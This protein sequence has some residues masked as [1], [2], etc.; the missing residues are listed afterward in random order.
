MKWFFVLACGLGL[1]S[2]S[3]RAA[4]PIA[5]RANTAGDLAAMCAAVPNSPAADAKINYCLGF[6]QGAVDVELHYAE[7]KK[8]FCIP[9][10]TKRSDT[11]RE[12]AAWARVLP[13][14]RDLPAAHGLIKFLGERF[15]CKS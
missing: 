14:N 7:E 3:V 15:P 11:M 13:A 10:G 9:D 8:P 4:Q 5:L 2:G 12:F 6:A 1:L